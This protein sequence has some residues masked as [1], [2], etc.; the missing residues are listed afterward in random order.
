MQTEQPLAALVKSHE[1]TETKAF[2]P[3]YL[4]GGCVFLRV[5]IGT[6]LVTANHPIGGALDVE[7]SLSG[8]SALVVDPLPNHSL[9]NVQFSGQ[10]GLAD[11]V[12]F[13]VALEFH[14]RINSFA[15]TGCQ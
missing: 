2:P 8:N 12:V 6:K 4:L 10:L 3:A 5:Q 11:A 1:K 7:D 15:T 9:S 14:E 13:Q